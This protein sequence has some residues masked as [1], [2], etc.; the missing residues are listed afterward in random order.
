MWRGE[1]I[2]TDRRERDDSADSADPIQKDRILMPIF[3]I[4]KNEREERER[5]MTKYRR[6]M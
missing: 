2:C 3:T 6:I 5:E 4:G 1:K